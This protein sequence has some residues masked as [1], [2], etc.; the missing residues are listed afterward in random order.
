[1][2]VSSQNLSQKIQTLFNEKSYVSMSR[3]VFRAVRDTLVAE[4]GEKSIISGVGPMQYFS[5]RWMKKETCY[6]L[7]TSDSVGISIKEFLSHIEG[8]SKKLVLAK[9][10]VTLNKVID[11]TNPQ[12][13]KKLGLK[14]KDFLESEDNWESN[15]EKLTQKIGRILYECGF[16]GAIVP[17]KVNPNHSNI[18]IFSSK[19]PI[20]GVKL[21]EWELLEG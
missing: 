12:I 21:V 3:I 8:D 17:S 1:M 16:S 18:V 11:L 6:V 2:D 14:M 5:G 7:Y 4:Y 15:S 9:I 10:R 13:V 19:T 20:S